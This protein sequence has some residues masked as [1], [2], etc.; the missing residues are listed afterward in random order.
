MRYDLIVF[1]PCGSPLI[2]LF[3]SNEPCNA[4]NIKVPYC[5]HTI[6]ESPAGQR[7]INH[8]INQGLG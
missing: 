6:E 8:N 3:D 4:R 5:S 7:I 2:G 1:L